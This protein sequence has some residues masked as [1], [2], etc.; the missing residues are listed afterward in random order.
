M[1]RNNGFGA[2]IIN[3]H[4]PCSFFDVNVL[5]YNFSDEL[6]FN[7]RGNSGVFPVTFQ[8]T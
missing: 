8:T 6:L 2:A 7:F 3:F 1:E 5:K 4:D